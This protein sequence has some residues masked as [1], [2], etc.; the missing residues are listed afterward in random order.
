[1]ADLA[2]ELNA[3]LIVEGTVRKVDNQVRITAQLIDPGTDKHLWS[4]S[5]DRELSDIFSLQEEI[6]QSIVTA[7]Q[8]EIG[9]AYGDRLTA[10]GEHRGL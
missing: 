7:L 3:S 10:H 4:E 6:A 5:Y 8:D 9:N 2:R 1:M